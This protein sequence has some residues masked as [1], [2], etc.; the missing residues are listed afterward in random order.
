MKKKT[1]KIIVISVAS[2]FTLIIV[3]LIFIGNYL[4]TFALVPDNRK[5]S[6]KIEIVKDEKVE[7]EKNPSDENK[8]ETKKTMVSAS[9][10]PELDAQSIINQNREYFDE[11]TQQIVQ[12]MNH[13]NLEI[14]S[15]DGLLLRADLYTQKNQSHL[16]AITV[17]GYKSMNLGV[18][19]P[20]GQFAEKGFNVLL[21]NNR[22]HG[23]S[24]GKYIGMGWL[25]KKDILK[26]IDVILSRDADAQIILWGVSMGGATVMMCSGENLPSN[27]KGIIEDCGYASVWDIFADELNDLYHLPTF[28]FL[29]VSSVI[30]KIRA[31][32]N[33]SEASSVKSVKKSKVPMLFIHGGSDT[34]VQTKNVYK[35]YEA[36]PTDKKLL[37]VEGA[38]HDRSYLLEP[39]KYFTTM[40]DFIKTKC[41]INF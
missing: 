20:A 2:F 32:Y 15:N 4:V 37:I 17:H 12:N 18:R 14:K 41:N 10:A 39:E 30:S 24:E 25:D 29:N 23:T 21:P 3:A 22:A 13:E 19:I 1:K 26:W 28:P 40:F 6:T 34:F 5:S 31:G 36:C 9:S 35:V 16:W 38:G 11:L 7:P 8:T 27:V 33:F